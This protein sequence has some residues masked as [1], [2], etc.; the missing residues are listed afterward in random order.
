MQQRSY[1]ER[2]ESFLVNPLLSRYENNEFVWTSR[3]RRTN[4][5]F[6]VLSKHI[7]QAQLGLMNARHLS[8]WLPSRDMGLNKMQ[9]EEFR[10]AVVVP[11]EIVRLAQTTEKFGKGRI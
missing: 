1:D 5:V 9:S 3:K 8:R 10:R 4:P 11:T 6:K 2:R 7:L